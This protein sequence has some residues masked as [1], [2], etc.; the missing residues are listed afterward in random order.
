MPAC[1]DT[2]CACAHVA[3]WLPGNLR[4]IELSTVDC[5][6]AWQPQSPVGRGAAHLTS[7]IVER[8]AS[9]AAAAASHDAQVTR[10]P[11]SN[12]SASTCHVTAR[13]HAGRKQARLAPAAP[14][15]ST[16]P[17]SKE[18][19]RQEAALCHAMHAA[20]RR[21]RSARAHHK[22]SKKMPSKPGQQ[23]ET[24]N[25]KADYRKGISDVS[26]GGRA[27]TPFKV[28]CHGIECPATPHSLT[29]PRTPT[30]QR[31]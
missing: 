8:R 15:R 28:P 19:R 9:K 14:A 7:R 10:Q 25:T 6:R 3:A 2:T 30:H 24:S 26:D 13:R 23:Q 5:Q 17:H 22:Q 27:R 21:Q 4:F 29:H 12:V 11:G 18:R 31:H 16:A 1:C 20:A